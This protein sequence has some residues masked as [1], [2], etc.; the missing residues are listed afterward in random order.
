MG[1]RAFFPKVVRVGLDEEETAS[2]GDS[3]ARTHPWAHCPGPDEVFVVLLVLVTSEV[4]PEDCSLATA[5]G[6]AAGVPVCW[7]GVIVGEAEV[8]KGL[9]GWLLASWLCCPAWCGRLR[10]E[11]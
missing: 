6:A 4:G 9:E 10:F 3:S 8:S 1:Y 7:L 11:T 5:G 2:P